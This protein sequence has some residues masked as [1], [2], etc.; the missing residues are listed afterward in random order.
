MW[1]DIL[2]ALAGRGLPRARA[3]PARLR[4]LAGRPAGHAGSATSRRSSAS[5]TQHGLEDVGARRPRLGRADRPAL[6]V[7]PPGRGRARSSSPT[8]ASSPTASGAARRRDRCAPRARASSSSHGVDRDG[9]AQHA[10]RPSRP[11]S[12]PDA[13]DEYFKA[14]AR[15]ADRRQRPARALPLG[16]LRASSRPTRASSRQLGVPTLIAVGRRSTSPPPVRGRR[17]ASRRRDPRLGGRGRS[18]GTGHFVVDDAPD[19]YAEEL[20]ALPQAGAPGHGT[21]SWLSPSLRSSTR[22][23]RVDVDGQHRARLARR[24]LRPRRARARRGASSGAR[25]GVSVVPS[26]ATTTS[27]GAGRRCGRVLTTSTT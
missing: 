7:R 24:A 15:R 25:A 21:L 19:R 20:V 2:P 26:T 1:R 4:R 8:P 18:T 12:T 5:A 10:R 3:R 17:I 6:G 9:F 23:G 27:N 16:R 14:F 22:A 13:V 11:G